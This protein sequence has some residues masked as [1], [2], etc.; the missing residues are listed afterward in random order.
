MCMCMHNL[1]V[2]D[3]EGSLS[4]GPFLHCGV[5]CQCSLFTST[6]TLNYSMYIHVA[7]SSSL[8]SVLLM[9]LHSRT[10]EGTHTALP[11][12]HPSIGLLLVLVEH[13]LRHSG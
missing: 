10:S 3:E 8:F 2:V 12:P 5:E 6:I 9:I 11:F 1:P 4:G 7:Y 13:H